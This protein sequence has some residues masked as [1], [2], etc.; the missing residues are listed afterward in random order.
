MTRRDF[1]KCSGAGLTLAVVCSPLGFRIAG[2]TAAT[3]ADFRPNAWLTVHPDGAVTIVV[4]KSEMGQG[5]HTSLPMIVADELEADWKR[6]AIEV[7]P[8]RDEYKDPL[9]GAQATGGSTSVRHLYEP[10]RK[11]GAAA[12]SMLVAAAAKRWSVPAGECVAAA[13]VVTHTPS[14]RT[15][16]YGDLCTEAAT[17]A[18]P[19]G[20]VV[21]DE[22]RRTLFTPG[23][24]ATD[25]LLTVAEGIERLADRLAGWLGVG[26]ALRVRRA[27]PQ[28]GDLQ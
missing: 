26:E 21:V 17:I 12:R 14:K 11:A 13:G 20:E 6:V 10:L 5:V 4:A 24:M 1:L 25:D 28:H 3:G 22:E 16:P 9:F 27:P 19:A 18:V 2:A 8:A 15:A 7:A 23:F